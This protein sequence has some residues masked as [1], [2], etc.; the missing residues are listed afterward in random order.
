MN[1]PTSQIFYLDYLYGQT[2]GGTSAGTSL[3]NTIDADYSS[4]TVDG[5][6]VG[7]GDNTTAPTLSNL[8]YIPVMPGTVTIV[9][10]GGQSA[11]DD[12]NGGWTGDAASGSIDYSSGAISITWNSTVATA[13]TITA[14]YDFNSEFNAGVPL[15]DL[16]ITS[17]PVTARPRKLRARWGMEAQQDLSAIHGID[18]ETELTAAITNEIKFEIDNEIFNQIESIAYAAPDSVVP[19]WSKSP[20]SGVPYVMHKETLKDL[21]VGCSTTIN[22][23]SRRAV[24][25]W[26]V[27]GDY[28]ADIVETL[29]NF[30]PEPSAGVSRGIFKIGRLAGRWDIY[31][32]Q[33]LSATS[34]SEFVMGYKGPTFN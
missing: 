32:N 18:A 6:S 10:G 19:T 9:T 17:S 8:S 20:P 5:E 14:T 34:P 28:V 31:R 16:I 24:G 2:K 27:C 21:F 1:G 26:I 13:D 12:G 25:N 30:E 7:T 4:E 29:S 33:Y 15:I 11:A 22:R 3:F 23:R